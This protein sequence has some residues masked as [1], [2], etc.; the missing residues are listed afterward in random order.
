MQILKGKRNPALYWAR[1]LTNK[2]W[3]MKTAR[4]GVG[5]STQLPL[6]VPTRENI[7]DQRFGKASMLSQDKPPWSFVPHLC[8]K[9]NGCMRTEKDSNL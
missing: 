5:L 8:A 7:A 9:A 6:Y 4:W 1:I 3:K 2:L